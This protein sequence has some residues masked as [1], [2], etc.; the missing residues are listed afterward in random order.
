MNFVNGFLKLLYVEG[1]D[2]GVHITNEFRNF[3]GTSAFESEPAVV[4]GFLDSF[5]TGSEKG[6]A[7]EDA[8]NKVVEDA[9]VLFAAVIENDL[10]FFAAE[11]AETVISAHCICFNRAVKPYP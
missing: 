10:F 7:V 5:N 8:V 6:S 2:E 1:I 4:A 11:T 9:D 3:N